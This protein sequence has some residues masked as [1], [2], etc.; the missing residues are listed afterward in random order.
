MQEEK[1]TFA[2][3]SLDNWKCDK[4]KGCGRVRTN[5]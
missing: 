1:V 5:N 2:K 4:T 3:I